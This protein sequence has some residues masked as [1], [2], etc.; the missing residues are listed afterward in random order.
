MQ[1][2]IP[3]FVKATLEELNS[4]RLPVPVMAQAGGEGCRR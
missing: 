1:I 4:R 2:E 3:S